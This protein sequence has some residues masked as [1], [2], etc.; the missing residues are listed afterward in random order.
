MLIHNLCRLWRIELSRRT[1]LMHGTIVC[2]R[3]DPFRSACCPS[4]D[5]LSLNS[6]LSQY[7]MKNEENLNRNDSPVWRQ[8]SRDSCFRTALRSALSALLL[9]LSKSLDGFL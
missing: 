1:Q 8:N 7:K 2:K 3:D 5:L 4:K 9:A 6:R